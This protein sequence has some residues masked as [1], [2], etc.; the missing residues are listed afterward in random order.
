[1]VFQSLKPVSNLQYISRLTE[2][3]VFTQTHE[4]VVVNEIYTDCLLVNITVLKRPCSKLR[5]TCVLLLDLSTAFDTVDEA[6]RRDVGIGGKVLHWFSSYQSNRSQL[7]SIDGLFS[8]QFSF[9]CCV[10]QGYYLAPLL[11]VIY[12][13]SLFKV[14]I[15]SVTSLKFTLSR[16]T[17]S[18]T[19]VSEQMTITHK[20]RR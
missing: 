19:S 1:M 3:A 15:P 10:P 9:E 18:C 11:F 13:F 8:R 6:T 4:H 5:M 17:R 20:M 12:T 14:T 2:K 16:T 7:V